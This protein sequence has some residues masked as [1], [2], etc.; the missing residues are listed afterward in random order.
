M[1]YT[2]I[3]FPCSLFPVP[4]SLKPR[5]LFLTQLINTIYQFSTIP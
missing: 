2:Y 4:C 3:I 5:T 1:R